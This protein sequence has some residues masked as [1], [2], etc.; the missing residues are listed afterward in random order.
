MTSNDLRSDERQALELLPWYVNGSLEGEE[1]ELVSRQILASLTCRK[2]FGRLRALQDL[3]QRE[4]PEAV[5]TGR[6]FERL[7]ARI[8]ASGESGRPRVASARRNHAR[9]RFAIAASLA[10]AVSALLWWWLASPGMSP[11]VYETM[12][13]SQPADPATLRLRVLFAPGVSETEQ[14][15]L[16]ARHGL[17]VV[18]SPTEDGIVTLKLARTSDLTAIVA[19]LKRDRRISLVT[20][21]PMTDGP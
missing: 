11:R 2:E 6:A 19:A 20:T 7:M 14:W 10:A 3:I 17:T 8:E 4:D 12:T 21:P 16:L 1:R 15:E 13:R 18:G 5:A 9:N